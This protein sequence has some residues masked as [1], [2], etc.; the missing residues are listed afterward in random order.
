MTKRLG[1]NKLALKDVHMPLKSSNDDIRGTVDKL[2]A[3]GIELSSCGVVYM[4]NKDEVK[5]AF[6]YAKAAG[7]SI[8]VG[9][10]DEPLLKFV[11]GMVKQTGIALAIHN[12]GPTDNRYPSPESVYRLLEGM[13]KKWASASTSVIRGD[14]DWTRPTMSRDSPTVSSMSI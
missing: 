6:R 12:H 1:I 11:E 4:T 7:I 9:S 10:P 8:L 2:K 5:N 14:W 3:A 13:D